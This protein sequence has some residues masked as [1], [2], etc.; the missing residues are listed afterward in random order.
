MEYRVGGSTITGEDKASINGLDIV[1]GYT[2]TQI[3]NNLL[4]YI[5]ETFYQSPKL[6]H[7]INPNL[8]IVTEERLI[9]Y[10]RRDPQALL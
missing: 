7:E 5:S 1:N 9:L 6:H 2:E 4:L 10:L 8:G 3:S